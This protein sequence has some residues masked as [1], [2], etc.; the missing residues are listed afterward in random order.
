MQK[1]NINNGD[2]LKIF[3][4]TFFFFCLSCHIGKK[5]KYIWLKISSSLIFGIDFFQHSDDNMMSNVAKP[6]SLG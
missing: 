4:E 5:I 2:Q 6:P 1:F 3:D